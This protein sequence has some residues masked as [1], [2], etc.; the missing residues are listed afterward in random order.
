MGQQQLG[1][2]PVHFHMC[3]DVDAKGGYRHRTSVDGLA[4]HRSFSR[5]VTVHATHGLLVSLGLCWCLSVKQ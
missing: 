1:R 3:G 4:I 2:Y 5:C